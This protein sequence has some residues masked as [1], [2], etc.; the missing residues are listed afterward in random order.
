MIKSSE[1]PDRQFANKEELFLE[2]KANEERLIDLK[3]SSI[4]KSSEKGQISFLN[5]D[6]AKDAIKA[7][8]FKAREDCIYPIVSTT[9]YMD[10]HSD[11][12]FKGCF[13][14]TVK[15]QQGKI[16]YT[17]DHELKWDSIIA[18]KEDVRMFIADVNWGI[19]GKD[20][21]G[22]TQAL[23]FEIR[24]DKIKRKDVLEAIENKSSNFENSIRMIYHKI[25]LGIDSENPDLKE[26]KAYYDE[27][28][29]EISN[30]ERVEEQGFFWGVEE[31]GI[32]KEASLVVSGGSNDATCIYQKEEEKEPDISTQNKDE[33]KT[34]PAQATQTETRKKS[35]I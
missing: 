16:N 13:K 22:T 20:Y 11:V 29:N 35:I 14:K 12:H 15:E 26:N 9:E 1:F 17:L 3:K 19:V 5:F 18:W 4:F 27:K 2:L 31:L 7:D 30:K 28:I 32:H 10:S 23:V 33:N 34:E 21:E 25:K 6:K 8:G 24:K